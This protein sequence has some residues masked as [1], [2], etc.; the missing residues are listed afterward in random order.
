M[1]EQAV[2]RLIDRRKVEVDKIKEQAEVKIALK[3][4]TPSKLESKPVPVKHKFWLGSYLLLFIILGGI[5]YLFR[6]NFIIFPARFLALVQRLMLGSMSVVLV[7]TAAKAIDL[8]FIK[9]ADD[10]VTKFNLKRILNLFTGI[11]ISFIIISIIFA[12]WYTAV[13]S[14]GLIS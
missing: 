11:F 1:S 10:I 13:V 8:Y 7:L 5:Y 2:N 6:L 12:N 9:Q 3:Q 14:L 4:A